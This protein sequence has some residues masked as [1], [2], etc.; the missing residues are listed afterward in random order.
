LIFNRAGHAGTDT[1]AGFLLA[2]GAVFKLAG[3]AV[4]LGVVVVL[5]LM[6]TA[7]AGGR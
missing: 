2:F 7:R 1:A 4:A 5:W 6:L 3:A